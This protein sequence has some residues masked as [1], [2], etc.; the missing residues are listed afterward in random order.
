MIRSTM[1]EVGQFDDA[2]D[3]TQDS[4][5]GLPYI[6]TSTYDSDE[7][8]STGE[9]DEEDEIDEAY[10]ENRVEDEDWEAAER[11]SRVSISLK[12]SPSE[13]SNRLHETVQPPPTARRGAHGE[14]SRLD[15][16][17]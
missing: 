15:L 1:P 11:G 10:D 8:P 6:D 13:A 3:P 5:S 12:T 2:E 4:R 16:F 7:F 9:S 17:H 14:R